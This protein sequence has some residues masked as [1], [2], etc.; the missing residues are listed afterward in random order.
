LVLLYPV[1]PLQDGIGQL[2]DSRQSL[3][4]GD[5][6]AVT[7]AWLRARRDGE[8]IALAAND[9]VPAFAQA[10]QL[11]LVPAAML[12]LLERTFAAQA[13]GVALRF[14]DFAQREGAPI[15]SFPARKL[16]G[17]DWV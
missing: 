5:P 11:G 10:I 2:F 4:A 12:D 15:R 3:R 14:V 17:V 9:V 8:T 1:V 7:L 6:V 16:E 13:P